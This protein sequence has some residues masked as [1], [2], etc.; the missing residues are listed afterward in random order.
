M[1]MLVRSWVAWA[2]VSAASFAAM[3]AFVRVSGVLLLFN[4]TSVVASIA[5]LLG[6]ASGAFAGLAL[7]TVKKLSATEPA[8]RTVTWFALLSSLLSAI[9]MFWNFIWPDGI[10]WFWL[11]AM[12]L[13][14]SLGQMGMTMAYEKAP[15]SQ[16]SPLGYASLV[17][18]GIIGYLAWGEI[19]T[20][21]GLAG[22][23][24]VAVAGIMVARERSEPLPQPP[25]AVPPVNL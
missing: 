13:L 18:A 23:I 24:L 9:P 19:P 1:S 7:A 12:G 10:D 4:P 16:V 3:G 17:F 21:L 8:I 5:G 2:L 11:L 6:L 20:S 14:G 15:A 25:S 22:A